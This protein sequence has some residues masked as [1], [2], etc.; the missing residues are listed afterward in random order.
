V[1]TL[2]RPSAS[3]YGALLSWIRSGRR[4]PENGATR[5]SPMRGG[6]HEKPAAHD[7]LV[8][9]LLDGLSDLE[10]MRHIEDEVR[11]LEGINR[12]LRER[13]EERML[14]F[15]ALR[16]TEERYRS[17][18]MSAPSSIVETDTLGTIVFANPSAGGLF[19]YD[20]AE[21]V[22]K[23]IWHLAAS[24]EGREAMRNL[25]MTR[26]RKPQS[27]GNGAGAALSVRMR[28]G[29]GD[30]R[31]IDLSVSWKT[32]N[33]GRSVGTIASMVDVTDR[34]RG[35]ADLEASAHVYRDLFDRA[36]A[37][38]LTVDARTTSIL[39]CNN[40]V[41]EATGFSR[42]EI[43]DRSIFDLYD[44][45]YVETAA[46]SFRR[47]LHVGEVRDV[48]LRL[49]RKN[50]SPLYVLE[51]SV[52]VEDENGAILA[53]RTVWHPTDATYRAALSQAFGNGGNGAN[54]AR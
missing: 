32:E 34:L 23:P 10:V 24:D 40:A 21:L 4:T 16:V 25:F 48:R 22:G 11:R 15:D 43:L 6:S 52:A 14:A 46:E 27:N 2:E 51:T 41:L 18:V 5:S 50:G 54:G 31:D 35:H 36:P 29:N 38:L 1:S 39:E 19:G 45:D 33:R 37:L 8:D 53:C 49:R 47:F 30:E 20:S 12:D 42:S 44:P 17:L 3:R 7:P 26:G 9:S 13:L 28:H